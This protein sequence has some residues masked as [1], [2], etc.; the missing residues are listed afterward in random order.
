M[1]RGRS[2]SSPRAARIWLIQKLMP[3]SKSTYVSSPQTLLLYL[4]TAYDFSRALREHEQYNK[5]L[6]LE[7]ESD[8]ALSQL[9][10]IWIQFK[11]SE[12]NQ[13]VLTLWRAHANTFRRCMRAW[14]ATT[15]NPVKH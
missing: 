12:M 4:L 14:Y 2:A 10:L 7:F 5:L 6:W 11:G 9:L 1:Y 8:T 15:H 3:R 13:A